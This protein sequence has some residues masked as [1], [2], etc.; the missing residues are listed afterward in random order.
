MQDYLSNKKNQRKYF[1]IG[2]I[3]LFIILAPGV[4][5]YMNHY[6]EMEKELNRR[7][8]QKLIAVKPIDLPVQASPVVVT[9]PQ[10]NMD[11]EPLD[12]M[13][14]ASN[15]LVNSDMVGPFSEPAKEVKPVV[16]EKTETPIVIANVKPKVTVITSEKSS[17]TQFAIQVASFTNQKS[18]EDL[19]AK[20]KLNNFNPI[21]KLVTINNKIYYRVFILSDKN[22]KVAVEKLNQKLFK[23]YKING[24][25]R[26]IK[27]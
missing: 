26:K 8:A 23:Q 5:K 16:V 21:T 12:S 24:Y 22:S 14:D 19:A 25:I 20:L 15:S 6:D 4:V 9:K 3:V 11:V 27:V 18:A 2:G 13:I 7:G 10:T 1:I 17:I